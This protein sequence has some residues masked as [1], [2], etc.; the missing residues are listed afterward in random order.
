MIEAIRG[1]DPRQFIRLAA[2]GMV[3]AF[4]A[5]T[6]APEPSI[7]LG[8]R[9][10]RFLVRD[11]YKV[12]T[13]PQPEAN[14]RTHIHHDLAD[15]AA[16][17]KRLGSPQDADIYVER[18]SLLSTKQAGVVAILDPEDPDSDVL[19]YVP[20]HHARWAHWRDHLDKW[21][22]PAAF[23]EVVLIGELDTAQVSVNGT[24]MKERQAT[25]IA[26]KLR[27]VKI[28]ANSEVEVELDDLGV[29]VA[30]SGTDGTK[31]SAEI[32][33]TFDIELPVIQDIDTEVPITIR[34]SG[35]VEGRGLYYALS[36]PGLS[37]HEHAV[38]VVFR[39]R[40]RKLLGEP[41]SVS[42]GVAARAS[43]RV[44]FHPRSGLEVIVWD[45]PKVPKA[46]AEAPAA[47][48]TPAPVSGSAAL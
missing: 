45:L 21:M 42:L 9:E 14:R 33:A 23:R 38:R 11:G 43:Y 8:D 2:R 28:A 35:K 3:D 34:V 16:Q 13:A 1:F 41:W 26:A 40:L 19:V 36:A 4:G 30:R 20:E 44:P 6:V 7:G 48:E 22:T 27:Q 17:I 25:S 47:P 24:R 46:P 5:P 15:F 31:V 10:G 39:E 12:E 29:I 37:A 18:L 32:P